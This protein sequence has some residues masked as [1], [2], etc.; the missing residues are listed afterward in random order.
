MVRKILAIVI[1]LPLAIVIIAFAVANRQIVSLSFDPF[2]SADSG[3]S[4]SLP[5]FALAFVLLI[6]G[7]MVG[8]IAAWIRQRKWR[9]AARRLAAENR[10]LREQRD[11]LVGNANSSEPVDARYRIAHRPPAV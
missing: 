6:L 1:L 3:L 11:A 9:R 2:G 4:L 10:S 8:G 7:V 5:L